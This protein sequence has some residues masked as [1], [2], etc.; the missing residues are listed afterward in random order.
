MSNAIGRPR[1]ERRWK[2]AVQFNL[3]YAQARKLLTLAMIEQLD[4]CKGIAAQMMI[5]GVKPKGKHERR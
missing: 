2:Y 1:N 5:L 3:S 4:Q